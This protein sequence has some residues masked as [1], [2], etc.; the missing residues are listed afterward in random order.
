MQTGN[1]RGLDQIGGCNGGE[2][3]LNSGYIFL[4]G[5]TGLADGLDMGYEKSGD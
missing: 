2:K 3:W 4:S 5:P 1:H